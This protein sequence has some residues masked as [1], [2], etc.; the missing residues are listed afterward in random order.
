[1]SLSKA[2]IDVI[3]G[4]AGNADVRRMLKALPDFEFQKNRAKPLVKLCAAGA[5]YGWREL[6]RTAKLAL[7]DL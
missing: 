3:V 5:D 4:E 2:E 7:T 6:E 1:M